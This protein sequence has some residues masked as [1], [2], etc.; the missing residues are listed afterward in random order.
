VVALARL[1][2]ELDLR[3]AAARRATLAHPR[4]ALRAE[5][6]AGGAGGHP[7]GGDLGRHQGETL[8]CPTRDGA[9]EAHGLLGEASRLRLNGSTGTQKVSGRSWHIQFCT[10]ASKAEPMG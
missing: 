4:I 5:V 2:P 6:G 3:A 7:L 8:R 10:S 9:G 1:Q